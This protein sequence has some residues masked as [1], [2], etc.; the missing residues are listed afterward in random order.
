MMKVD[1]PLARWS[2]IRRVMMAMML[3]LDKLDDTGGRF[4]TF[5]NRVQRLLGRADL[6][7][8][9]R[10]HRFRRRPCLFRGPLLGWPT[11]GLR[12][13]DYYSRATSREA[14]LLRLF[15]EDGCMRDKTAYT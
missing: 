10:D 7:G 5:S 13:T 12:T 15:L 11:C 2:Q 6:T 4:C 14:K 9:F 8:W 3:W 1:D